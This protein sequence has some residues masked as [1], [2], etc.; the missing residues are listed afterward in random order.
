[1][2]TTKRKVTLRFPTL[3]QLIDYTLTID[4]TNCEVVR[5]YFLL[6]CELT[7]ADIELAKNGYGA[8]EVE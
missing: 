4:I 2:P 7:E 1:M 6:I 8:V 3:K 5:S